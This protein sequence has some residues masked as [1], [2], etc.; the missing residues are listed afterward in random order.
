VDIRDTVTQAI[1]R[2]NDAKREHTGA[3]IWLEKMSGRILHYGKVLDILAQHH[4]EYVALAWGAFKFVLIVSSS[5]IP[6][7]LELT[8]VYQG[9]H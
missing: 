2:Y 4:P 9:C 6:S 8:S 7:C 3:R 5:Q 1:D